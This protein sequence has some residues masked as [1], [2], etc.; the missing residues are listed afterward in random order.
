M[1]NYIEVTIYLATLFFT[2]ILGI[3]SKKSTWVNNNYIPLQNFLI[4]VVVAIVNF[5][6]TEDFAGSLIY[7]TSGLVAGGGYDIYHG[8]AKVK[9][10]NEEWEATEE[11]QI[12]E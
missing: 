3:L 1:E 11:E 7:L 9:Q 8:L 5:I 2:W 4:G 6:I 10:G 12:G